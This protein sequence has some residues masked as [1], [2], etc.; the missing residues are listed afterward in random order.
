MCRTSGCHNP[1][2]QPHCQSGVQRI[3]TTLLEDFEVDFTKIQQTM[4]NRN[5]L[6]VLICTYSD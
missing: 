3:E 4:G 2:Q 5:Y 1:A 6:L